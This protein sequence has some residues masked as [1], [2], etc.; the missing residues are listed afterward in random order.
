MNF[1]NK[2]GNFISR[3]RRKVW[4]SALLNALF[5]CFLLLLLRPEY[6]TNDDLTLQNFLNLSKGVQDPYTR[7][8][9][10]LFGWI[11]CIA[12]RITQQLPWYTLFLYALIF[13]S[14]T[15][16]TNYVLSFEDGRLGLALAVILMTSIG[17]EGYIVL[18]FTRVSGIAGA[19]GTLLIIRSMRG[20]KARFFPLLLG[21]L[22]VFAGYIVRPQSAIAACG[23]ASAAGI[24][25]LLGLRE[26]AAKGKRLKRLLRYML[27]LLPV[28]VLLAGSK[29]L[30]DHERQSDPIR[31]QYYTYGNARIALMDHG[32]P[33]YKANKEAFQQ[34]GINKN[35]WKLYNRWDFY[36]PEKMSEDTMLQI[37]KLQPGYHFSAETVRDFLKKYPEKAFENPVFLIYLL[38]LALCILYGRGGKRSVL[39]V[40]WQVMLSGGL[41]LYMFYTR[42]YGV[43]RVD[44]GLWWGCILGILP[45]LEHSRRGM[46][47]KAAILLAAF[48]LIFAQKDWNTSYRRQT[49]TERDRQ[50]N[51]QNYTSMLSNDTSHLYVVQ[52]NRFFP[53]KA[54]APFD[55]IPV[56]AL[57]NIMPLGGWSTM[58][59]PYLAVGERYSVTNPYRDMIG[60]KTIRLVTDDPKNVLTYL[61]DYYDPDCSVKQVG[62]IGN[63]NIYEIL[64]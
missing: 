4:F 12:Y 38:V 22:I 47:G 55:R 11:L 25:L 26:D 13:V 27:C 6:E 2:T 63:N 49:G 54:Y 60:S 40:L 19:A 42:R 10:Y 61:H 41:F 29:K 58:S 43:T 3:Y 45:I 56:G 23:C 59:I 5:L 32:F 28:L 35:A 1:W 52:T 64:A 62:M 46:N 17:Y 50:I 20:K 48:V 7:T 53:D 15:S 9:G 8:S 33:K 44:V 37:A 34:L 21:S 18:N 16:V 57:A 36:D 51:F 39:T 30:N 24:Y 14:L 31:Q